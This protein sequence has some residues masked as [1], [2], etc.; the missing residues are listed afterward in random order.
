MDECTEMVPTSFPKSSATQ[1][2][3]ARV[4]FPV[5]RTKLETCCT[6]PPVWWTE[7]GRTTRVAGAKLNESQGPL[8]AEPAA[9]LDSKKTANKPEAVRQSILVEL[10]IHGWIDFLAVL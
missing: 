3:F 10:Q 8:G 5:L 4:A 6:D 2:P 9:E 7:V 1:D